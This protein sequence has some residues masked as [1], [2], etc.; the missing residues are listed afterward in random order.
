MTRATPGWS[1]PVKKLPGLPLREADK[2]FNTSIYR[3]RY[4][5]ERAIACLRAWRVLRADYRR[6]VKTFPQI[7][8]SVLAL[9]FTYTP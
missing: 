7:I 2:A 4:V 3:V 9:A 8:T 1:T 6:P 5:V